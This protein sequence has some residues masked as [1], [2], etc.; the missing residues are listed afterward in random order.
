MRLLSDSGVLAG[1]ALL[2]VVTAA[3]GL[4]AGIWAVA[5]V[6]AVGTAVFAVVLP[7]GPGPVGGR[8][9]DGAPVSSG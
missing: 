7:K 4:A 9:R 6:C 5:V 8:G 1:P 2:S 3:A